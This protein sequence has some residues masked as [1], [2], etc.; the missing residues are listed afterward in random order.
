MSLNIGQNINVPSFQGKKYP[1][2]PEDLEKT[3]DSAKFF[4]SSGANYG[5]TDTQTQLTAA[6]VILLH[7]LNQKVDEILKG[8]Q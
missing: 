5:T 3:V 2:K 7:N 1:Y 4:V 8:K 6:Q